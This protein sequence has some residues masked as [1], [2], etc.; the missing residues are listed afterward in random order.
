[1][2]GMVEAGKENGRAEIHH[3]L[4]KDNFGCSSIEYQFT[5]NSTVQ[6]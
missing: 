5:G 6:N 4:K 1:M 2:T 3:F